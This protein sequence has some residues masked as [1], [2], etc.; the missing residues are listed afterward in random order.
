MPAWFQG[1]QKPQLSKN[2]MAE[3]IRNPFTIY[4]LDPAKHRRYEQGTSKY[5]VLFYDFYPG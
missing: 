1:G 5:F 3:L 2:W 4:E